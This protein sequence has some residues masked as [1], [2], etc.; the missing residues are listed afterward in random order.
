[1]LKKAVSHI[2]QGGQSGWSWGCIGEIIIAYANPAWLYLLLIAEITLCFT[3][4]CD[5]IFDYSTSIY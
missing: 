1:M 4:S 3:G 5:I 2:D